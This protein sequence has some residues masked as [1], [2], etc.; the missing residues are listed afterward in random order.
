MEEKQKYRETLVA[1]AI[2]NRDP[3]TK[4]LKNYQKT[5]NENKGFFGN[6]KKSLGLYNLLKED[7]DFL[8]SAS[9]INKWVETGNGDIL[10]YLQNIDSYL[11]T[12][13]VNDSLFIKRFELED[14]LKQRINEIKKASN[15]ISA[16]G[17]HSKL[18]YFNK[19]SISE[20]LSGN[21]ED[22]GEEFKE[23]TRY[24]YH[25][26]IS[27]H[28]RADSIFDAYTDLGLEIPATIAK[29]E[30]ISFLKVYTGI[31]GNKE[32]D[33]FLQK[34]VK[35]SFLNFNNKVEKTVKGILVS[36][37]MNSEK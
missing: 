35:N 24:T 30:L 11:P 26:F 17:N 1:M 2:F 34:E 16:I 28:Y 12:R 36:R 13:I 20:I 8:D 14:L 7:E 4:E 9:D 6:I 23:N 10:E 32:I 21:L 18:E 22:L 15:E 27:A 37:E 29:E 31:L 3:F 33:P 25:D 19:H 5:Y